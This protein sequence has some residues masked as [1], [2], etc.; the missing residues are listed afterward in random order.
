LTKVTTDSRDRTLSAKNTYSLKKDYD[1]DTQT[2]IKPQ[3]EVKLEGELKDEAEKDSEQS[4]FKKEIIDKL[5]Q[6]KG[7]FTKA[8]K[9]LDI[10]SHKKEE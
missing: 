10:V 1:W 8:I 2:P 7:D 4:N 6:Q 5:R 3:A 9:R